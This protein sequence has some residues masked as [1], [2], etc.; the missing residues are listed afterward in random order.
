MRRRLEWTFD[1]GLAW[2]FASKLTWKDWRRLGRDQLVILQDE[3]R[4]KAIANQL[5]DF[6]A[7]EVAAQFVFEIV[8]ASNAQ[9]LAIRGELLVFVQDH[10]LRRAPG[11]SRTA[12]IAPKVKV[13][14][15]VAT[16]DKIVAG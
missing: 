7:A 4:E 15:V 13:R 14:F 8:I 1:R 10:E 2:A 16:A 11:L 3:L 5:A 6:V 12:D 9:L